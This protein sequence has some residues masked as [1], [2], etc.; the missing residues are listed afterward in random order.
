[1][2]RL[3]KALHAWQTPTFKETLKQEIMQLSHDQLPLQQGLSFGNHVAA[4]PI[5]V[6]IN[7]VTEMED[8]IRVRVGILYQSIIAGCSCADDPTPVSEINEYCEVQLD[9]N[10]NSAS[11]GITLVNNS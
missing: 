1:M 10:K 5:T 6:I 9:I 8:V 2:I 7:G 4:T 11:T 3:E